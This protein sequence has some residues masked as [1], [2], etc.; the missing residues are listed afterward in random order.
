M[1]LEIDK[2]VLVIVDLQTT[3]ANVMDSKA[4]LIENAIRMVRGAQALQIPVIVTEQV[5]L[6]P[7]VPEVTS[8]LPQ[9]KAIVKESFSCSGNKEFGDALSR[10]KRQQVLLTGI[11][12]HVCV[13]Q[14]TV[15]LLNS[16]YEVH[17]VSDA[18]SSRT[19]RNRELGLQKMKDHGASITGTE[20]ALFELLKTAAH[21]KAREIF[22][23]VK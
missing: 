1:I 17:V 12:A 3:L 10:Q 22:K 14:T 11:E 19:A 13:Y 21:E 6:G 20:I 5:K 9:I 16:G 7:T 2:A 18:V 8:L 15:D 23:I 4:I